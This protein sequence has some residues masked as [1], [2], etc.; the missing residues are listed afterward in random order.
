MMS[1]LLSLLYR[2]STM[3]NPPSD[4][5]IQVIEVAFPSRRNLSKYMIR[6]GLVVIQIP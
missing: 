5:N 3:C 1:S 4:H 6:N 2:N